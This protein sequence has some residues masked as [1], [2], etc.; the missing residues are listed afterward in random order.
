MTRT[1]LLLLAI[2]PALAAGQAVNTDSL[3]NVERAA[4]ERDRVRVASAA[5]IFLDRARPA[6]ARLAAVRGIAAF[7]E[8]QSSRS[9]CSAHSQR[10]PSSTA[11]LQPCVPRHGIPT[12]VSAA[13]RCA[14]SPGRATGPG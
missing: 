3:R 14:P 11:S 9:R 8:Q 4:I 7:A 12:S 2:S 13:P 1:A 10:I 6:A 5:T